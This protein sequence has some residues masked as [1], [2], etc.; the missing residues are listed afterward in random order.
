MLVE[1]R[2]SL[3]YRIIGGSLA[4]HFVARVELD[5]HA[6]YDSAVYRHFRETL[7]ARFG[8]CPYGKEGLLAVEV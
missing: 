2:P 4:N 7:H 5:A 1:V 8:V 6:E 3:S